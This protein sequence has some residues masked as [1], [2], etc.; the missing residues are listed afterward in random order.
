MRLRPPRLLPLVASSLL[1]ACSS[2]ASVTIDNPTAHAGSSPSTGSAPRSG[3]VP[4]ASTYGA[5]P[6]PIA[7]RWT[8]TCAYMP[9][10]IVDISVDGK[11]AVGRI[12][13]LGQGA[14]RGYKDGDELL[15]LTVDDFG[16]W[17]GKL[18]WRSVAGMDRQDPIR[19]VATDTKLDAIMTTDECFKDMPRTQ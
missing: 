6:G 10:T 17:V 15:H 5:P 18:H 16:Q 8:T 14:K 12:T 3:Y 7:G 19:F 13:V 4:H 11:N 9:D 1:L 2:A